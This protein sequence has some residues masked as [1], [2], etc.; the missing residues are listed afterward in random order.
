MAGMRPVPAVVPVGTASRTELLATL[1]SLLGQVAYVCI[2]GEVPDD[3]ARL[4][5]RLAHLV[6]TDLDLGA[7]DGALVVPAGVVLARGAVTRLAERASVP[8]RIVTRVFLPGLT[9]I[10]PVT[11][12]DAAWLRDRE[13]DAPQIAA[14]SPDLDRDLFDHTDPRV[15]AW[16]PADEIGVALLADLGDDPAGWSRRT[17]RRLAL[18]GRLAP[19]RSWAGAVRRSRA[20]RAQRREM[21]AAQSAQS[22][23]PER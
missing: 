13:L 3:G 2:V 23:Q 21:A 22:A 15:R 11:R 8:G 9:A 16:V 10:G 20:L 17:G 6:R 12:W 19:A 4:P 5:D 1:A 14:A 7:R 18:T